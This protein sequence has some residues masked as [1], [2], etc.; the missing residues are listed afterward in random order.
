M[1]EKEIG[2]RGMKKFLEELEFAANLKEVDLI[3]THKEI[4][5]QQSQNIFIMRHAERVDLVF[6]DWV[7][8]CFDEK[9]EYLQKDLNLPASL[10][11]R[12]LGPQ[13][14]TLDTP[15][16]NVGKFQAKSM[17]KNFKAKNIAIDHVYCSPAFRCLQ[18]CDAFLKGIGRKET[19][20]IRIEPALFEW[21]HWI[22]DFPKLMSA[23]ELIA[24]GFNIDT[25]YKSFMSEQELRDN[26]ESMEQHY[27]RSYAFMKKIIATHPSGNCLLVGHATTLDTCSRNL[28]NGKWLT[29]N[30]LLTLAGHISYC[31]LVQLT[32]NK[33]N[34]W[35][36]V[37][38]PCPSMSYGNNK[39]F[40]WKVLLDKY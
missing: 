33:D 39:Q 3:S 10:P 7:S 4:E 22:G 16:T 32:R 35:K 12:H 36:L 29:T 9:G 11:N 8:C 26:E 23:N 40:K 37:T 14:Y 17:G 30:E 34:N 2:L 15:I 6:G 13:S 1:D 19:V 18:T 31:S 27:E 24:A 28:L 38:P 20:K 5:S 21:V 25:E